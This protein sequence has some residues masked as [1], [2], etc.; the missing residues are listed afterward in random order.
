MSTTGKFET[1]A[2]FVIVVDTYAAENEQ[3]I[4]VTAG[5]EV[6]VPDNRQSSTMCYSRGKERN[7]L[8]PS[9]ILA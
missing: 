5:T 7:R 9:S 3:Q 4:S 6:I 1:D 8:I 2:I